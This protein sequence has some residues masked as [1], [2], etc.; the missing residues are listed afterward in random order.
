M[1]KLYKNIIL[2]LLPVLILVILLPVNERSKFIGLKDDCFNHGIWIHDR[3]FKNK[4]PVDIAFFGSSKTINSINDE[5]IEKELSTANAN[6]VNFGYCRLGRNFSL[7][8]IKKVLKNKQPK[9]LIIEVREDEDRYSHPIFPYIAS[10]K[11]VLLA[12]PFFNRDILSD[13]YTH[14]SYKIELTQDYLYQEDTNTPF[15]SEQFGFASS[16]DTAS[17]E[18]LQNIKTNKNKSRPEL[19]EFERDFHI[20]FSRTYLKRIHRICSSENI[21]ITFL[22]IPS[23]GSHFKIPKE[24]ETYKKYGRVLFPPEEIFKDPSNWHD[25]DHFNQSG[26]EKLSLWVAKEIQK[27]LP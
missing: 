9:Q 3:I 2:F 25:E 23:F 16:P 27:D 21:K 8:L 12:N 7:L 17:I 24:V 22:Y 11:E 13:I 6:I 20:Q 14:L 26:A 19:K 18:Y 4:K 1:R 5:L 10:T 15:S